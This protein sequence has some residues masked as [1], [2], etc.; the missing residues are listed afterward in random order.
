MKF[1]L[2]KGDQDLHYGVKSKRMFFGKDVQVLEVQ[3]VSALGAAI[4][5]G[6]WRGNI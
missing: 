2:A 6:C 1:I 4:I 5:A 3:D